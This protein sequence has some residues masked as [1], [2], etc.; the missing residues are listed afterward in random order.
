MSRA[1][2]QKWLAG[3]TVATELA[4]VQRH[5]GE[6]QH[7]EVVDG[8]LFVQVVMRNHGI[9]VVAIIG[10][11]VGGQ[12]RG[13]WML[14]DEGTEVIVALPDGSVSGEAVIIG[15]LPT[16]NTPAGLVPGKVFIVGTEVIAY[17]SDSGAAVPLATKADV[18]AVQ[19]ALDGH[20][21]TYKGDGS[22]APAELT[23]V[24]PSVPAPSGTTVLK[25]E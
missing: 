8:E 15:C 3:R 24:N 1:L 17:D 21:H 4:V 11:L 13:V 25:A 23:T 22:G 10:A 7:W 2:M 6:V 14:P 18:E 19:Q 5:G 12:G 9:P 20:A 16:R